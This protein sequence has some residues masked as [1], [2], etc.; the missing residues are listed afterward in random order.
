MIWY[1]KFEFI[2]YAY[3]ELWPTGKNDPPPGPGRVRKNPIYI[4]YLW[5]Q[6]FYDSYVPET[7]D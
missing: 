2:A 6:N 4:L 3:R 5:I 1:T 7:V